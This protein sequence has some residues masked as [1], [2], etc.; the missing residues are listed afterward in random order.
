MATTTIKDSAGIDRAIE[1]PLPPGRAAAAASK[2]VVLSTEDLAALTSTGY[3]SSQTI[4]RPANVTPYS[5]GDVV[6][7]VITFT[8]IGPTAGHIFITSVDIEYHVAAIPSGLTTSRLHLYSTTPSSALADNAPWDLTAGDRAAY[9]GYIDLSVFQD[10]GSTLYVQWSD[11][12]KL[13]KLAAA[14]T[15][16]FAYLVTTG[17]FTPVANSEVL[18]PTM[19]AISV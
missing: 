6:G 9:M 3:S 11:T 7:G 5:A 12:P 4:T 10:L 13:V 14:S 2:P 16:L 8:S 1:N 17:G 18:T 15:S 19:R